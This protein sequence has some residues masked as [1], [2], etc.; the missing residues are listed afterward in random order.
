ML[1]KSVWGV[2]AVFLCLMMHPS[3]LSAEDASRNATDSALPQHEL[4]DYDLLKQKMASLTVSASDSGLNGDYLPGMVTILYGKDLAARGIGTVGEA[5]ALV[6]GINVSVDSN[7]NWITVIRGLPKTFASGHIKFLLNGEPMVTVLGTDLIPNIPIEQVEKIEMVRG[8][9]SAMYGESA[10]AGVLNVITR[11][12]EN[13][14]F[15]GA[16]RYDS[17]LCGGNFSK[18]LPSKGLSVN[19][20]LAF[21]NTH[22]GD[23]DTG[24]SRSLAVD[25]ITIGTDNDV[26]MPSSGIIDDLYDRSENEKNFI[27]SLLTVN[28]KGLIVEGHFIESGQGDFYTTSQQ[29]LLLKKEIRLSPA[30]CSTVTLGWQGQSSKEDYTRYAQ[31]GTGTSL[32]DVEFSSESFQG[33]MDVRYSGIEKHSLMADWF[34]KKTEPVKLFRKTGTGQEHYTYDDRLLNSLML[35]DTWKANDQC[36]LTFSVRG[37]IYDDIGTEASPRLAAVYRLNKHRNDTVNHLLKAQ[38]A[39]AVRRQTFLELYDIGGSS[40]STQIEPGVETVDS[41]EAGYI[42]RTPETVGRLTTFYSEIESGLGPKT[43]NTLLEYSAFGVEV[44][45]EQALFTDLIKLDMNGS[46]VQAENKETKKAPPG[47]IEWFA[48]AAIL[49]QV[50]PRLSLAVNY[51]FTGEQVT[52]TTPS[53]PT[54]S[55]DI[56]AV[57]QPIWKRLTLRAGV[58][59]LFEDDVRY[60]SH[61]DQDRMIKNSFIYYP[62]DYQRP[63]RWWW[64]RVDYDF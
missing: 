60:P 11:S 10:Y 1:G 16:G 45:L 59:N 56:T 29:G 48:N 20:N 58:K 57:C 31:G 62:G 8:P 35:Q 39:R 3:C 23:L 13:S 21:R 5:M 33:G 49:W 52:D 40:V 30:L 38:L 54:H 17:Y 44:E 24:T 32:Y 37:D 34:I 22:R 36:A 64:V 43:G 63:E 15:S 41:M 6:P 18:D 27:S 50:V 46:W 2:L 12:G 61:L 7:N 51:R 53:D 55:T 42:L 9:A 25:N 14:I 47:S 26:D 28:F 4:S 19:L